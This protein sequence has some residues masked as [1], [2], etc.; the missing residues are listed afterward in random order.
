MTG[1]EYER[2]REEFISTSS[3]SQKLTAR[4]V[5]VEEV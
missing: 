4:V 5:A 1:D 3:V 2:E